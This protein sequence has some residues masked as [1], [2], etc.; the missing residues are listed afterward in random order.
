LFSTSIFT[1]PLR[2]CNIILKASPKVPLPTWTALTVSHTALAILL[3]VIV[4]SAVLNCFSESLAVLNPVPATCVKSTELTPLILETA[5]VIAV[6]ICVLSL[7]LPP[8]ILVI[9]AVTLV[10][11]AIVDWSIPTDVVPTNGINCVAAGYTVYAKIPNCPVAV[12]GIN[13]WYRPLL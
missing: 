8:L 10:L 9:A 1:C 12:F 11:V 4:A 5:S 7:L 13:S 6:L 2:H 3:D